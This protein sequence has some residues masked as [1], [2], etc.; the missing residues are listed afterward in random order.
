M[1]I[2]EAIAHAREKA[3]EKRKE[4]QCKT[5]KLF[6]RSDLHPLQGYCHKNQF[7]SIEI[8]SWRKVCGKYVPTEICKC[9]EEYEQ[10]AEWLEELKV[11]QQHEIICNKGYNS[12]YNKALDDFVGKL[13]EELSHTT[14]EK[15][16]YYLAN[17]IKPLAEQL[18]AG[19]ENEQSI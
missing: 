7:H 4:M 9:A 19:G 8:D 17:I 10:I 6:V 3:K 12:G 5:C 2:D 1:S 11:Y 14:L 15:D 13:I 16:G 18:K